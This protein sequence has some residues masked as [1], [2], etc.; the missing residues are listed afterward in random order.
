MKHIL[1]IILISITLTG[2]SQEKFEAYRFTDEADLRQSAES[3][4]LV[5]P[6]PLTKEMQFTHENGETIAVSYIG[7]IVTNYPKTD[8]TWVAEMSDDIYL[9]AY[10][11]GSVKLPSNKKVYTPQRRYIWKYIRHWAGEIEP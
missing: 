3:V 8:S 9:I 4:W 1:L 10:R 11:K 6:D 2:I 5:I 7:K